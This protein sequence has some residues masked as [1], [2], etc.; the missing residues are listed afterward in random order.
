MNNR[1]IYIIILVVASLSFFGS[2][3]NTTT[4]PAGGEKDTIPPVLIKTIPDSGAVN[5]P[6]K[7][8]TVELRFNEYVTFK[9]PQ[10]YIYL[11]PPV[12]KR[13]EQKIRGKSIFVTFP[14][15]LD[16][17]TTYTLNFGKSIVDNNES[18]QF[19]DYTFPFS[20]GSLLDSLICTGT[21]QDA[22]TLLPADNVTVAFYNDLSDSVIFKNK[23][24]AFSKS[25]KFGY[26]VVRNIGKGPFKVFAFNDDNNN[27]MYDAENEKIAFSDSVIV[28]EIVLN[29]S[30]K[31]LQFVDEKD[32][33]TA[34][35]RPSGISL[36]LFR[37]NPA[38]QYI[39]E[40][41]RLHQR[42]AYVKF[43]TPD[44]VVYSANFKEIDSLSVLKEMS[45]KRD[46][47]VLW[48]TDTTIAALP[49]SLH[50]S[51]NYLKTDSLGNLAPFTEKFALAAPKPK[52]RD[53]NKEDDKNK[54]LKQKEKRFDLLEFEIISDPSLLEQEGFL[55]NFPNPLVKF[56]KDSVILNFKTPKGEIGKM[57]FNTVKDTIFSRFIR[58]MPQGRLLPGYEY[59]LDIKRNAFKDIYKHT[60]DSIVKSVSLPQDERMSKLTLDISNVRGSYIVEL[61]NIT[62]DKIFRS[63]KIKSD[64]KLLFPYLQPGKYS[65][66]IVQDINGNGIIDTGNVIE[67][68]QPEKVRLF[69]LNNGSA[70]LIIPES[71]EITQSININ[72]IFDDKN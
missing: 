37:E 60:N 5:F 48:I 10:K 54:I 19:Y 29:D 40:S 43:S 63:Y 46:S 59:T 8:G 16:S 36:Y 12:D 26:F 61:T 44:A 70:I 23:P 35:G 62:R 45:L 24:S 17:A 27:N 56:E 72:N 30:L 68:K 9:E 71:S 52:K 33:L 69:K 41:K 58:L 50:L 28:P 57:G 66:K 53:E 11:S 14:S 32:T 47:L 21:V 6:V 2:C 7:G 1:Y 49:D 25:D 15:N 31:E 64:S 4:P 18:N 13:V 20:T 55:M 65:V 38:K 34:L 22:T 39:K 67:K 3:A 51:V 42:M